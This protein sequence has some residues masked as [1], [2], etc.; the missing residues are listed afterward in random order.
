MWTV[1]I[2]GKSSDN[3]AGLAAE[4]LVEY[5]MVRAELGI[6]VEPCSYMPN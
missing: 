6:S 4:E 2:N 1:V 5:A 3:L